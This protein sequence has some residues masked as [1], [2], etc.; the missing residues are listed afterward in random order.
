MVCNNGR[1]VLRVVRTPKAKDAPPLPGTT[2]AV[3]NAETLQP[4]RTTGRP[5]HP[6]LPNAAEVLAERDESDRR[7]SR[8]L[9]TH[10]VD[11]RE[12]GD[13]G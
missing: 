9:A 12:I 5:L 2:L 3:R 6:S 10:S 7:G 13:T 4:L 1:C 11:H 8:A